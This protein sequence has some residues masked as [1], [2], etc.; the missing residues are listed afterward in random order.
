MTVLRAAW[1]H[2]G[3][4]GAGLR[5]HPADGRAKVDWVARAAMG[6]MGARGPL[7]EAPIAFM[8]PVN[9]GFVF[10]TTRGRVP[11]G[12]YNWF[13]DRFDKASGV[14]GWRLHHL[15]RTAKVL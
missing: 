11:I 6:A 4:W 7:R 14:T 3:R 15:R 5:V 13:K 2:L 9:D 12:G 8:L 10:S 1:G